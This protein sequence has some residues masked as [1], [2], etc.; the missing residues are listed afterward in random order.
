MTEPAVL[1]G[2]LHPITPWRRAW[3][4]VTGAVLFFFRDAE[5]WIKSAETWPRWVL[6][7]AAAAVSL[8]GAGYGYLSWRKTSY[9]LTDD[10]LHVRAG[11][12]FHRRHRFVLD[13][14]QA[15]DIHRPLLGRWIGVCSLRLSVSGQSA[16]LSYLSEADASALRSA[17]LRRMSGDASTSDEPVAEPELVEPPLLVVPARRLAL[18]ILLEAHTMI[19]VGIV[20]IGGLVPYLIFHEPLALLSL[21]GSAGAVWKMTYGRWPRYHG[22]TLTAAPG[23]YRAEYGLLDRRHQTYRHQRTQAITLVQPLLWRR[24]GWVQILL[25]TAGYHHPLLLV[26][27]ATLDEAERL[28]ADLYGPD[29]V[30][31]LNTQTPAPRRARWATPW[32]HVLSCNVSSEF[33]SVWHGLFLRNVR[34]LC[35]TSKTQNVETSQGPWQR[36]L[37]LATVHLAVAGGPALSGRH[38]DA[39]E[40]QRI[41]S[42]MLTLDR[43][44]QAPERNDALVPGLLTSRDPQGAAS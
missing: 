32:S 37:G 20:V 6:A 41:A 21:A 25:S 5:S 34:T 1:E 31:L 28:T 23:G 11:I 22:W 19:R 30:Q 7:L 17:L 26:P 13:H 43:T 15:A 38:R 36:R 27:V 33:V 29:A 8:F 18:S 3:A 4:T 24:R 10:A 44:A 39:D 42:R 40:A 9:Q 16:M 35:P 14:L 2:R 12:L